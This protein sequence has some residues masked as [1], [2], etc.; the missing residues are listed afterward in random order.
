MLQFHRISVVSDLITLKVCS[1]LPG[2]AISVI[3]SLLSFFAF[4]SVDV[5][6]VADVERL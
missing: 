3:F 6:Y 1:H 2:F 5:A 4:T